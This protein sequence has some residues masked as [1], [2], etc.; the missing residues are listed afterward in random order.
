MNLASSLS[1]ERTSTLERALEDRRRHADRGVVVAPGIPVV[2]AVIRLG[3]WLRGVAARPRRTT[4]VSAHG[5]RKPL[6]P[7]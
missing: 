2:N 6:S 7:A 5:H 3:A 4:F 1:R